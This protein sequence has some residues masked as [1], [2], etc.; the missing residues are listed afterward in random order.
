MFPAGVGGLIINLRDKP[1]HGERVF[2]THDK[3]TRFSPH[4]D[5]GSSIMSIMSIT[6]TLALSS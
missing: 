5:L 3:A 1:P 6:S 2:T 4:H